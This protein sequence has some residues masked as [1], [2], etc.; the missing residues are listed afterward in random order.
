MW[1]PHSLPRLQVALIVGVAST[2]AM[3]LS[4]EGVALILRAPPH[5]SVARLPALM[6]A[7]AREEAGNEHFFGARTK[8][9]VPIESRPFTSAAPLVPSEKHTLPAKEHCTFSHAVW[10]P[11]RRCQWLSR[12]LTH[13]FKLHSAWTRASPS[14]QLSAVR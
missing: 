3:F 7:P 8:V 11:T 1:S 9:R 6:P 5:T 14:V 4:S 13:S 10:S 12:I 2:L